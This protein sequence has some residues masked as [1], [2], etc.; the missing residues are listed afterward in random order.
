MNDLM[1]KLF[2]DEDDLT[3]PLP[4]EQIGAALSTAVTELGKQNAQLGILIT[5]AISD[6]INSVDSKQ[7]TIEKNTVKKWTF[8]VERDKDNLMSR[9]IATAE[10]EDV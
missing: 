10:K 1:S 9:I 3:E 8:K 7:I 4:A 2:P 5:K 6:A